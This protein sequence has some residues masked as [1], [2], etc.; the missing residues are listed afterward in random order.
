MVSFVSLFSCLFAS[1]SA[2]VHLLFVVIKSVSAG[3]LE[4]FEEQV[5]AGRLQTSKDEI[6]QASR[7]QAS[8]AVA[9]QYL[10]NPPNYQQCPGLFAQ[11]NT[12]RHKKG[13]A[14][15]R[16]NGIDVNLG[17]QNHCASNNS[18]TI[19]ADTMERMSQRMP[20]LIPPR[21]TLAKPRACKRIAMHQSST[22]PR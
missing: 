8:L 2:Q 5:K 6:V 16:W 12:L 19:M 7:K 15:V 4:A 21:Q 1:L 3:A 11:I 9:Q 10:Y 13:P 17:S 22:I 18:L 20:K 14:W